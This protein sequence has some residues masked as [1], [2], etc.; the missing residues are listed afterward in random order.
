MCGIKVETEESALSGENTRN[1]KAETVGSGCGGSTKASAKEESGE[2]GRRVSHVLAK[3]KG[4]EAEE[5]Y[6]ERCE[7]G[8]GNARRTR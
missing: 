8:R 2:R 6:V 3:M 4:G 5:M 1:K 7:K